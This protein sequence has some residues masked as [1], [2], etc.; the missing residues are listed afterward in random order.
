MFA[1]HEDAL[2]TYHRTAYDA[3]FSSFFQIR[4]RLNYDRTGRTAAQSLDLRGR[5]GC[6]FSLEANELNNTG[7]TQNVD[8]I[9]LGHLHKHIAWEQRQ[10]KPFAPVLPAPDR[11][12]Q[13]QKRSDM[14]LN[15]LL[16]NILLM[17][18]AGI[19][20]I[21]GNLGL[22]KS[23]ISRELRRVRNLL[24]LC[25]LQFFFGGATYSFATLLTR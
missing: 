12:I 18:R 11:R 6:R 2:C 15:Q 4:M 5:Y 22:F 7:Q 1:A 13:R 19:G 16:R 9:A 10:F 23:T 8:T 21:P 17:S 24:E 3:Y 20:R 14:A 25:G